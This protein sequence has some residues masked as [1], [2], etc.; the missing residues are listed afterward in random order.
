MGPQNAAASLA[1]PLIASL[2]GAFLLI[3]LAGV[4]WAL[5]SRRRRRRGAAELPVKERAVEGSKG[6]LQGRSAPAPPQV[7]QRSPCF[8]QEVLCISKW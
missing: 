6:S 3:S 2:L 5:V 7:L 8:P 1:A 4:C